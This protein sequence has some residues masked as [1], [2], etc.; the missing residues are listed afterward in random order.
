MYSIEHAPLEMQF[1]NFGLK[2]NGT[3]R[4]VSLTLSRHGTPLQWMT[5]L[6]VSI[7]AVLN[8][9]LVV[10]LALRPSCP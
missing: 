5:L 2:L 1:G 6:I 9:P 3:T 10:G 8:S 7:L 4:Q